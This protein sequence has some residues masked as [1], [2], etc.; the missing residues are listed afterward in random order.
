VLRAHFAHIDQR[1]R[2]QPTDLN[3]SVL[4]RPGLLIRGHGFEFHPALL[5]RDPGKEECRVQPG[6]VWILG[7]HR[8]MCGDATTAD[9][10]RLLASE[11]ADMVFTD[12]PYNARYD[13]LGS[14]SGRP[15]RL[16]RQRTLPRN[17]NGRSRPLGPMEGDDVPPEEYQESSSC[18]P[19]AT[20]LLPCL[21]VEPS[22]SAAPRPLSLRIL[23]P[24]PPRTCTRAP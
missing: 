15:G 13:P 9:V 21:A 1:V 14:P 11:A 7:R 3:W 10:Q 8:L 12:P 5:S 17:G 6:E 18:A 16:A 19:S 22:T 23:T 20:L 4:R 2:S 24:S